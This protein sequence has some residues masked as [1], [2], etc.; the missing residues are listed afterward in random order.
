MISDACCSSLK[1]HAYTLHNL[2][3]HSSRPQVLRVVRRRER[4]LA[5]AGIRFL[6][7]CITLKDELFNRYVLRQNVFE[8]VMAVFFENGDRYN[9]LN[10][11]GQ[12]PVEVHF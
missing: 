9:L 12:G 10:R 8:P 4:W 5:C 11:W 7:T 6:R 1:A 3:P 2:S